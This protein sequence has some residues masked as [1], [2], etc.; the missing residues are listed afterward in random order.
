MGTYIKKGIKSSHFNKERHEIYDSLGRKN[1]KKFF[2]TK[3][4]TLKTNDKDI[5]GNLIYYKT[6]LIAVKDTDSN[7]VFPLECSIKR[8]DLWHY[9]FSGVDVEL[10]K[11]K[12]GENGYNCMSNNEATEVLIIPLKYVS[13]AIKSC[14]IEY[15][16]GGRGVKDSPNFIMP[17]HGCHRV[18]KKCIKGVAQTG[19]EED[20]ARI[21]YKYIYHF[22][23]SGK[24]YILYHKPKYK[25]NIKDHL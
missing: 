3:G 23:K 9:I 12:Y 11:E 1:A 5:E 21:P 19:E 13:L 16:G 25:L 20:F 4:F 8:T 15:A 24:G 7:V 18:R 6:D 22:K 2:K 14:G 10:R 17:K